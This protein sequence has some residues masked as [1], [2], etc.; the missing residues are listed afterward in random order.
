MAPTKQRLEELRAATA[1]ADEVR[2]PQGSGRGIPGVATGGHGFIPH[3]EGAAPFFQKISYPEAG[4]F[5]RRGGGMRIM[6]PGLPMEECRVSAEM[7]CNWIA[8]W[9][10]YNSGDVL[11]VELGSTVQQD[12]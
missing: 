4:M 12:S 2:V 11:P 7:P 9:M 5:L 6:G 3:T 8:G 10:M 1:R